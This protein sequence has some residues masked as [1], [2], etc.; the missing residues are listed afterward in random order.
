[1]IDRKTMMG[2]G[3]KLSYEKN[4]INGQFRDLRNEGQG[5]PSPEGL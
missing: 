2:K 5:A 4:I 1:M 3:G